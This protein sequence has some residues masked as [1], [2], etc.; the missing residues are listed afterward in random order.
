MVD[1]R[2]FTLIIYELIGS[3][4]PNQHDD[5]KDKHMQQWLDIRTTKKPV[6]TYDSA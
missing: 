2:A 4:K 3:A 1:S 5:Q 6:A